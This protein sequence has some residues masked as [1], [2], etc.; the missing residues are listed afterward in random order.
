MLP[1]INFP[2]HGT[3][4]ATMLDFVGEHEIYG[5]V[6]VGSINPPIFVLEFDEIHLVLLKD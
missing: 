5:L 3:Y 4:P 6:C 2:C 1:S